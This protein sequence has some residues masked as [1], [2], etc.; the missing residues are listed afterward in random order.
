MREQDILYENGDHFVI[1][2]L[3]G[4][5]PTLQSRG[6]SV[7]KNTGTHSV[8]VGVIGWEGEKGLKRAIAE[9]DRRA[10]GVA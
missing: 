10:G 6:Y 7:Y 3:F 2:E 9:A 4:S 8:R 5:N 1:A